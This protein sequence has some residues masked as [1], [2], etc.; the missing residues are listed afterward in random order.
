MPLDR[1]HRHLPP[2][3]GQQ[4]NFTN[5]ANGSTVVGLSQCTV[6]AAGVPA[7]SQ[8]DMMGFL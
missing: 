5:L 6:G 4:F 2:Q 1:F 3:I 8:G 7:G